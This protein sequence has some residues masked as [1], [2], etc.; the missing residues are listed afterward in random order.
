M[1]MGA[2]LPIGR[3][4]GR[5][6]RTGTVPDQRGPHQSP[7]GRLP[8]RQGRAEEE[9]PVPTGA[10]PGRPLRRARLIHPPPQ[11]RS[12]YHQEGRRVRRAIARHVRP[13]PVGR[14]AALLRNEA[15]GPGHRLGPRFLTSP[16]IYRLLKYIVLV[17]FCP[18]SPQFSASFVSQSI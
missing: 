7:R 11:K 10:R 17:Q 9:R 18:P 4:F 15:G 14:H 5:G 6:Q 2:V 1:S 16:C 13:P 12:R 3:G 8:L